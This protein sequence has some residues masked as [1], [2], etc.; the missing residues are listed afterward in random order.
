MATARQKVDWER[1][2]QICWILWHGP[3]PKEKSL[4]SFNPMAE[5]VE[6][7]LK[8]NREESTK[9]LLNNAP[10]DQGRR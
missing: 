5:K 6:A 9:F 4:D 10:T 3:Q 2:A 7:V 8:L 1:T